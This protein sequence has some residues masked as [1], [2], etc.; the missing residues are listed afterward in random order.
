[1]TSKTIT[2]NLNGKIEKLHF[3]LNAFAAFEKV[4][5]RFFLDFLATMQEALQ[6]AKSTGDDF[7][8]LRK[9]SITDVRAFLWAT[10]HTYDRDGEPQWPYTLAQVGRLI[11]LD[12]VS[13]VVNAIMTGQAEN[14][15]SREEVGTVP[16]ETEDR[17]T[18]GSPVAS[19]GPEFG[20]SDAAV[21]ASLE[22][23]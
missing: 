11:D 18:E 9:F 17:P 16:E 3:N 5:G 13:G 19:G 7:S 14:S 6:S 1:M 15:P 22:E 12:N 20:P 21:L 8:F 4:T 2:I 10:L 23:S